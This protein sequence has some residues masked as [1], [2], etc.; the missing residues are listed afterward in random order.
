MAVLSWNTRAVKKEEA[1]DPASSRRKVVS[2]CDVNLTGTR[3]NMYEPAT[4][5]SGLSQLDGQ[6]FMSSDIYSVCRTCPMVSHCAFLNPF[7]HYKH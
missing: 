1:G 4:S 7:K 5:K 6:I 3:G 2:G